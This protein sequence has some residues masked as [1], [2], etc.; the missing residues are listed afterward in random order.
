[1]NTHNRLTAILA[2]QYDLPADRLL[3]EARLTDL[4]IDSL[5]VMELLFEIEDEFRI[6]VPTDQTELTTI[7]DV[8]RYI[9]ALVAEQA[10]SPA[11]PQAGS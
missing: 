4:G 10:P 2:R 9:D 1:M 5:G 8:T 7:G 3:P 6:Q 11:L